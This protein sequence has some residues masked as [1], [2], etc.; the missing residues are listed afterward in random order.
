MRTRAIYEGGRRAIPVL[1]ALAATA[2]SAQPVGPWTLRVDGID[3]P[4][5]AESV[6]PSDSSSAAGIGLSILHARGFFGAVIDS[7]SS[8]TAYGRSGPVMTVGRVSVS[9]L[10]EMRLALRDEVQDGLIGRRLD[11]RRL[12]DAAIRLLEAMEREG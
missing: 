1:V 11:S 9:G 3:E 4:W 6:L 5:P 8:G 10:P 7:V 2:A 12:Q